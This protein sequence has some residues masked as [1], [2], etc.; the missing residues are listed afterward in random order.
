[1]PASRTLRT[2]NKRRYQ[3]GDNVK[4]EASVFSLINLSGLQP[5]KG[6][7][8]SIAT[9]NCLLPSLLFTVDARRRAAASARDIFHTLRPS[10]FT[11]ALRNSKKLDASGTFFPSLFC[12]SWSSPL[13]H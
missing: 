9:E 3:Y 2:V 7:P 11:S 1:M 12:I 8:D 5:V 13:R 4:E 10:E 6:Y